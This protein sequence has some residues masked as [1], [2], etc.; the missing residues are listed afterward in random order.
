[1][2][3]FRDR[4]RVS[5][6]V[7]E[8]G[9]CQLSSGMV[10]RSSDSITTSYPFAHQASPARRRANQACTIEI[11]Y[12]P[13]RT[14]RPRWGEGAVNPVSVA[15]AAAAVH[16]NIF[17]RDARRVARRWR[18][19]C[20]ICADQ[21]FSTWFLSP[22][23]GRP[24]GIARSNNRSHKTSAGIGVLVGRDVRLAP[25]PGWLR[26]TAT[27]KWCVQRTRQNCARRSLGPV[28]LI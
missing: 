16:E 12:G 22:D 18:D 2:L 23:R 14:I 1:M 5:R 26:T 11:L 24:I 7:A 20:K 13:R 4:E 19:A 17:V 21:S 27:A 10:T 28:S 9:G 3:K 6:L 15:M 8:H 25:R